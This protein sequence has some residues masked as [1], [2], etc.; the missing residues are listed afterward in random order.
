MKTI[1]LTQNKIALVDDEDFERVS[2]FKWYAGKHDD[3]WYAKTNQIGTTIGTVSMHRFILGIK[4]FKT[5]HRDGN[6]LNN[7]K[8]NLRVCND[9]Q[10]QANRKISSNNLSG[11]KGVYRP[12]DRR[13]WI[14]VIGFKKMKVRLGCFE[15]LLH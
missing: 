10:N 9:S 12:S 8:K 7:Q 13:K 6:G 4:K 2:K 11:F 3:R 14:S 15:I 5:D 1:P